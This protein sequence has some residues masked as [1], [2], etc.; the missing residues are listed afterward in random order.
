MN[1]VDPESAAA[2]RRTAHRPGRSMICQMN[3]TAFILASLL[4]SAGGMAR[5]QPAIEPA[6]A[7]QSSGRSIEWT[8]PV[9]DPSAGVIIAF[10]DGR[11]AVLD[12]R[13]GEDCSSG[14]IRL[15]P[16]AKMVTPNDRRLARNRTTSAIGVDCGNG[17]EAGVV[18]LHDRFKV[19]AI[20]AGTGRMRWAVGTAPP[21]DSLP[22]DPEFLNGIVAAAETADGVWFLRK[23]G[24]LALLDAET[25]A[26][27]CV[28]HCGRIDEPR[29]HGAGGRVVCVGVVGDVTIVSWAEVTGGEATLRTYRIPDARARWSAAFDG[30]VVLTDGR[31][32]FVAREGGEI[33]Q[34]RRREA[35]IHSSS[36]RVFGARLFL[37]ND[38][39]ELEF[40]DLRAGKE[41][42][43]WKS[44]RNSS[45]PSGGDRPRILHS[46]DSR[47]VVLDRPWVRVLDAKEGAPHESACAVLEGC[48]VNAAWMGSGQLVLVATRETDGSESISLLLYKMGHGVNGG[49]EDGAAREGTDPEAFLLDGLS[50]SRRS[51]EIR[52]DRVFVTE[53][54]RVLSYEVPK[55]DPK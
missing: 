12:E 15:A 7:Y 24:I 40:Y 39:S 55:S 54:E 22:D 5:G 53:P 9:G 32:L 10:S 38:A 34:V 33:E 28:A 27:R 45:A 3:G 2:N 48:E 16:G 42:G 43:S 14:E 1:V 51:V 44:R 41:C 35:M 13:T 17:S 25:G 20:D 30:G 50:A 21:D 23:D 36:P 26:R 18:Y 8:V 11:V 49:R 29:L 46:D 4:A 6:W 47:L 37:T 31:R 19:V 52:R